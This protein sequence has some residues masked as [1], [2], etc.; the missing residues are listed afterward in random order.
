MVEIKPILK[1]Y[2]GPVSDT[3]ISE[4]NL[5]LRTDIKLLKTV[6]TNLKFDPS[7]DIEDELK[8]LSKTNKLDLEEIK[9]IIRVG[10]IIFEQL[11]DKKITFEDIESDFGKLQIGKENIDKIKKFN[12][13]FGKKYA[14]NRLKYNTIRENLYSLTPKLSNIKYDLNILAI[15]RKTEE[16][17]DI[18]GQIPVARIQLETDKETNN[19]RGALGLEIKRFAF[20]ATVSDLEKMIDDLGKIKLKLKALSK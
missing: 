2:K 15:E 4:L 8:I 17:E 16:S 6:F 5:F 13:D 20:N 3:F 14:T 10:N 12:D 19:L 11:E 18:I 9:A 7:V 1:L